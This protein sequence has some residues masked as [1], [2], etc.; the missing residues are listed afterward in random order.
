MVG[1]AIFEVKT[2]CARI[3]IKM[4]RTPSQPVKDPPNLFRSGSFSMER[5]LSH[6]DPGTPEESEDFVRLI[7]EQRHIDLSSDR[8]GKTGR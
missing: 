3:A 8:N 6:I 7:Y 1:R 4:D 5:L 2:V